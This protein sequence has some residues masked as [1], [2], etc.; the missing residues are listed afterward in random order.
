MSKNWLK[1]DFL[2]SLLCREM[3]DLRANWILVKLWVENCLNGALKAYFWSH[4]VPKTDKIFLK[5]SAKIV[6][7]LVVKSIKNVFRRQ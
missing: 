5:K 3:L 2:A 6:V 4:F 7:F 1:S